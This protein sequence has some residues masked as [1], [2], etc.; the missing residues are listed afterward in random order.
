MTT[1]DASERGERIAREPLQ[2]V[3][4][5]PG[6]FG[7]TFSSL[8]EIWGRREL[9]GLLTRRELTARY[10]DSSLGI[11]WSLFR[12]LAQLLVYYFA[13]GV[14]LGAARTVPDF[15]IFVFVG[16]TTWSLFSEI[17]NSTTSSIVDNAGIVRKIQLPREVFPLS[18]VG[19]ALFSFTVQLSILIVATVVFGVPPI[20]PAL[21]L[22][23][24]A[25]VLIVVF[26]TAVGL[27]LAALNVYYRDIK[28]IVEVLL[29]LL[30]WGSPIVYSFT[31]VH[32]QIGGTWIESLYLA[33]PITIAVLGMQK[34]L[35]ISG[36][37]ATGDLEQ[38]FPENLIALLLIAIAASLVLLWLS[39]RIFS[40]LQRNFAQEL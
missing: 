25:F 34:A 20:T 22:A 2:L 14:V 21:A 19:S 40:R 7:G 37:T 38:Y 32:D 15:A 5:K 17:I 36:S 30:F 1:Q 23:P 16:L 6:F 10:K 33:N 28:H 13:I 3:G 26:A 9:L 11:A 27:L 18:S 35:W 31:Y 4:S 29:I 12:P 39:Q 24:L 8:S